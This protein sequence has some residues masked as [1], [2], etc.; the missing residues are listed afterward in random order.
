MKLNIRRLEESDWNI[1]YHHGGKVGKAGKLQDRE[2]L[3]E[4]GLCGLMVEK[5][6]KKILAGFLYTTNSKGAWV[7]YIIS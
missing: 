1:Y 2:A 3:P 5:G 6:D 7:E 4:N